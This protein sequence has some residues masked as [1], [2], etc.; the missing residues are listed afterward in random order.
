MKWYENPMVLMFA[1]FFVGFIG[2][3]ISEIV[4]ALAHC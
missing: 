1:I 2:L 4:K 3:T